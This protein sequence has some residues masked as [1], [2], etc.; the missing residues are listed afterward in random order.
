MKEWSDDELDKLFRKSAE[1]LVPQFEPEDWHE[2]RRRLDKAERVPGKSWLNQAWLW[3][4]V[5]ILVTGIGVYS[6]INNTMHDTDKATMPTSASQKNERNADPFLKREG[7]TSGLV[8]QSA[9]ESPDQSGE[10]AGVDGNKA[11]TEVI[12]LK[13][14]ATNARDKSN[15]MKEKRELPRNLVSV[16]GVRK[17]TNLTQPGRGE[18]AVSFLQKKRVNTSVHNQ[19][20]SGTGH[21]GLEENGIVRLGL[22]S[23]QDQ[24]QSGSALLSGT[25]QPENFER[26]LIESMDPRDFHPNANGLSYPQVIVKSINGRR[27]TSEPESEGSSRW[28]IRIGVSPDLSG[29]NLKSFAQPGLAA[30]L[31]A[32]YRPA[33]RFYVQTGVIRSLKIYS[34]PGAEYQWPAHW[35]QKQRPVSVD[36]SCRVFEI[37]LNIRYDISRTSNSSWFAGAGVSSYKME[38]EKY[39]YKYKYNNPAI[40]WWKWEGQTGWYFLSHLNA[41]AGYERRLTRNFSVLAEPYVRVPVRRVGFGKINLFTTGIWLSARYTPVLKK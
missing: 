38:K 11:G 24:P 33:D 18:G 6:I 10:D 27:G 25:D 36:G 9:R 26:A 17:Q 1:E 29:V 40:R 8:G 3:M 2:L 32:E 14:I 12:D 13:G 41:S 30:S 23:S 20:N 5:L 15:A 16:S 19:E 4:V 7:V 22:S 31:L 28:A 34:A 35:Y 37:P 21:N 39:T